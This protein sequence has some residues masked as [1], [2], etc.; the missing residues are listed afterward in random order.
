MADLVVSAATG[1]LT[2][3]LKKLA[4]ALVEDYKQFKGVRGEINSLT[5]E[6]PAMHAFLLK[7]SEEEDP[8]VQDKVWMKEVR[9]LSYD[10]EDSFDEF[11]LRVDDRSTNPEGL[12]DKFNNFVSKTKT[13][14]RIAKAIDDLKIQ[15]KEVGERN[16]RYKTREIISKTSNAYV[17]RRALAVFENVSKLVGLERPTNEVIEV[18]MTKKNGFPSQMPKVLSIVGSGGLGKTTLA[19]QVYQKLK[20]NFESKAFV[21]VS[22]NPDLSNVLRNILYQVNKES[23]PNIQDW[24]IHLLISKINDSLMDKRYHVVIDDIW[25]K[26]A[27]EIINYALYKNS[28]DSK[29]I[30]TTRSH[31]VAK[32]CCSSDDDFI[33]KIKPLAYAESK[34][35]FME[36]LFGS[37]DKCP[38]HLIR[39]SNSILE[40][41]DGLPL[42]IVSISGLLANKALTEDEWGRV[43]SSIGRGLAKNPDVKS[44]MQILSLSYFDLP[45][46][47]KTCLLYLSLFPEDSVIDKLRLV[48]RLS[49]QA[50]SEDKVSLMSELNLSHV[51]SVT[52]FSKTVKLPSLFE[53]SLLRVLDL[54]GCRQV[55]DHHIAGIGN[56]FQLKYLSLRG[57]GVCELPEEIKKLQ[58]LETLDVNNSKVR[59]LPPSIAYLRRLVVL[60]VGRGEARNLVDNTKSLVA[61]LS[62]E[63]AN[64]TLLEMRTIWNELIMD[65][66]ASSMAVMKGPKG[67]IKRA[68]DDHPK[69]VSLGVIVSADWK[70]YEGMHSTVSVSPDVLVLGIEAAREIEELVQEM[71][72]RI[73]H[74]PLK[75]HGKCECQGIPI[76][77][78]DDSTLYSLTES[79]FIAKRNLLVFS[80]QRSIAPSLSN[81]CIYLSLQNM[82]KAKF[83][84][85]RVY[86]SAR[87]AACLSPPPRCLPRSSSAPPSLVLLSAAFVDPRPR[88]LPRSSST[89]PSSV[90]LYAFAA[91][92]LRRLPLSS[93]AL[94]SSV[95]LR[96][97]VAVHLRRQPR[98]SSVLP[99]SVLLHAAAAVRLRRLPWSSS[100]PPQPFIHAGNRLPRSSSGPKSS[101]QE[102]KN[103]IPEQYCF[104][105]SKWKRRRTGPLDVQAIKD[106]L[107]VEVAKDVTAL[108]AA[109][110]WRPPSR[111]PSLAPG[112]RSNCVSASEVGDEEKNPLQSQIEKDGDQEQIDMEQD[113]DQEQIDM[114]Q[115]GDQEQMEMGQDGYQEQRDLDPDSIDRLSEPTPC[116]LVINPRG[117]QREVARG[118]VY[119]QQTIL[120]TIPILDGYVVVKVEFVHPTFAHHVLVPPPNDETQNLGQALKSSNTRSSYGP[121]KSSSIIQSVVPTKKDA[122]KSV[123][124]KEQQK[125]TCTSAAANIFIEKVLGDNSR[126]HK[127]PKCYETTAALD[128]QKQLDAKSTQKVVYEISE[129]QQLTKGSIKDAAAAVKEPKKQPKKSEPTAW[130]APNPN[131]KLGQPMLTPKELES[132]GPATSALHA[133]Y[134]KTSVAKQKNGIVVTYKGSHLLRSLDLEFFV[135]GFSDLYELMNFDALDVSLMRCYT[136]Q[137]HQQRPAN[138]C[139]FYTAHHMT[140]ALGLL[141]VNEPET[142]GTTPL[143]PQKI[144]VLQEQLLGFINEHVIPES[145]EPPPL[146][147]QVIRSLGKD[148]CKLPEN[149]LSD[150]ALGKRNKAKQPMGVSNPPKAK[151]SDNVKNKKKSKKK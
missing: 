57:T 142:L 53:S 27:W 77:R 107:R 128:S 46:Y 86:P 29:I 15:I 132:V 64:A 80:S 59:E 62:C 92:H 58:Y 117:Y 95:L 14:R 56:L 19:N 83:A 51:R 20:G 81:V 10:M 148:F 139:A 65:K 36:R 75:G 103:F 24:D 99:S 38:A 127:P 47:L 9:E 40:K 150:D 68:V 71:L 124:E 52:V 151:D 131:F 119:P 16:A 82:H 143:T 144:L 72:T 70:I 54:Q 17:D 112:R 85:I 73:E 135:V 69:T 48:R 78:L 31:H 115:D 125:V 33:Y 129:K 96:A 11:R 140:E 101:I 89:P 111:N 74:C 2:P 133:H 79:L 37:E 8:D 138:E 25:T 66:K 113:G 39:V 23:H 141:D 67:V 93:S 76:G 30:T 122:T 12:I 109:Q 7:M 137:C 61:D 126:K 34:R 106:E 146:S 90:L 104:T 102:E 116:S 120:H 42:A 110:G 35:L 84:A 147:K 149:T 26:D 114:E 18:M 49:L 41:C 43:L 134:M 5:E 118:Q 136:L 4:A 87:R 3:L 50:N 22:R 28:K 45:H 63:E 6:L 98:S 108:L 88:R 1:A 60:V 145:A 91:V 21:S 32:T 130:S 97:I 123:S 94:P 13:R 105:T 121:A 100:V 55:E 44:M